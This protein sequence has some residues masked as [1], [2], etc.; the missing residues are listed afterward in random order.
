MGL[1]FLF[2]CFFCFVVSLQQSG[3]LA[4]R[5]ALSVADYIACAAKFSCLSI[6][7]EVA[8]RWLQSQCTEACLNMFE[9][10]VAITI[11]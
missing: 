11:H 3:V 4:G 8:A 2:V 10:V 6:V 9:H 5:A 7:N 1:L